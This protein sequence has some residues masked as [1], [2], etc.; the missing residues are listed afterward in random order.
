[1]C[2]CCCCCCCCC[3]HSNISS[4]PTLPVG[5]TQPDI[6]GQVQN[7]LLIRVQNSVA[8]CTAVDLR[9]LLSARVNLVPFPGARV[10]ESNL[11]NC[12]VLAGGKVTSEKPVGK[13]SAAPG[14]TAIS[15]FALSAGKRLWYTQSIHYISKSMYTWCSSDVGTFKESLFR[16]RSRMNIPSVSSTAS[17][18]GLAYGE[19]AYRHRHRVC[20][21]WKIINFKLSS[22]LMQ[23]ITVINRIIQ[24]SQCFRFHFRLCARVWV[25]AQT[26]FRLRFGCVIVLQLLLLLLLCLE[27]RRL[28]L[29]SINSLHPTSSAAG[30][31][32]H[33]STMCGIRFANAR[34]GAGVLTLTRMLCALKWPLENPSDGARWEFYFHLTRLPHHPYPHVCA[35][36]VWRTFSCIIRMIRA[37]D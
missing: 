34:T 9:S 12:V 21:V 28:A 18:M 32:A 2:V 35:Y 33:V 10:W 36:P 30:L 15:S 26:G 14:T 17:P 25:C 7:G 24:E 29:H 19:S 37:F 8:R 16:G 13:T 27:K 22:W 20:A 6:G 4:S 5:P 31:A 11:F 3:W 1:M 23:I